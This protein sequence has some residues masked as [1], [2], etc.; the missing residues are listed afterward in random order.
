MPG[1]NRPSSRSS[2][3]PDAFPSL[4]AAPPGSCGPRPARRA[5][6]PSPPLRPPPLRPQGRAVRGSRASA[7]TPTWL[8]RRAGRDRLGHLVRYLVR[9]PLALARVTESSGGQLLSG[10]PVGRRGNIARQR[11]RTGPA[12]ETLPHSALRSFDDGS[13]ATGQAP[14]RP[15]RNLIHPPPGPR[16]TPGDEALIFLHVPKAA[17]VTLSTIIRSGYQPDAEEIV[18]F[19]NVPEARPRRIKAFTDTSPSASTSICWTSRCMSHCCA[20]RSRGSSRTTTSSGA[21]P[22]TSNIR[23]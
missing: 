23:W 5:A 21:V 3:P 7:W 16:F 8:C 14:A 15:V 12:Q 10:P 20:I 4:P 18:K 11:V 6:A 17:G 2:G 13:S 9:P 19:T 22:T 1:P